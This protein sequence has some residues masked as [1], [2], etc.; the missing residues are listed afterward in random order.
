MAN[1]YGN[2]YNNGYQYGRNYYSPYGSYGYNSYL[3]QQYGNQVQQQPTQ[4]NPQ[5]APQ[6][7]Y[8][9]NATPSLTP[10]GMA[11]VNGVEGAKAFILPP[12]SSVLLMDSDN[13]MF[14][15]KT[16]NQQGQ[17]SLEYYKFQKVEP[18]QGANPTVESEPDY[19]SEIDKLK[20]DLAE[21]K[22]RL[23]GND[24]L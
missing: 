12:N 9:Q 22:E 7:A 21:L 8:Y 20:L 23:K 13:P 11:Y 14:Y 18:Q 10:M 17:C 3:Q 16:S 5:N 15:T 1:Y 4:M 2:G 6:Q 24:E 19:R